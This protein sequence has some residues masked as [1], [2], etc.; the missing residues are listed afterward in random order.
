MMITGRMDKRVL[1]A[2]GEADERL[3]EAKVETLAAGVN[4]SPS[5]FTHLFRQETGLTP[6]QYLRAVRLER[7]RVLVTRTF[8]TVKQVMTQ[9]GISAASHFTRDFRRYHGV[10]PSEARRLGPAERPSAFAA[11]HLSLVDR[12]AEEIRV[13]G[14]VANEP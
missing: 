13:V 10:T 3:S 6:A 4:L 2:I 1:W 8:L 9:V 7:A 14:G 12:A 5:H 11:R